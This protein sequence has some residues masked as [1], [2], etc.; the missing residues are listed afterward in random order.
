MPIENGN[1]ETLKKVIDNVKDINAVDKNG[2]TALF[3]AV[4]KDDLRLALALINIGVNPN[5][6]D[7][8]GQNVLFNTILQVEKMRYF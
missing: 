1:L 5:I 7:I 4:L 6:I 2:Q 3:E 8:N